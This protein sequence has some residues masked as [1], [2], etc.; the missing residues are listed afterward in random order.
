MMRIESSSTNHSNWQRS[1][2]QI[3]FHTAKFTELK[4]FGFFFSFLHFQ[5]NEKKQNK[6][7]TQAVAKI[8]LKSTQIKPTQMNGAQ[9]GRRFGI[10]NK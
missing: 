4:K 9:S 7:Y 5:P 3:T 2:R 8:M 1:R 6:K 10:Q